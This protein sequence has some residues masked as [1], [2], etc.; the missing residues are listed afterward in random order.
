MNILKFEVYIYH[1]CINYIGYQS[2]IS[3][4]RIEILNTVE[5]CTQIQLM[6]LQSIMVYIVGVEKHQNIDVMVIKKC[7]FIYITL[8]LHIEDMFD[9]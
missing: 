3:C 7:I 8:K 1:C 5:Y 2:F 9:I 4:G 6:Q